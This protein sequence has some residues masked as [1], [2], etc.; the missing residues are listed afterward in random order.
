MAVIQIG[1][2]RVIIRSIGGKIKMILEYHIVFIIITIILL[3]YIIKLLFLD[4]PETK[5]QIT[6]A[7][8][9]SALN[10]LTCQLV[11]LGFFG[12]SII[13]YESTGEIALNLV[14]DEYPLFAYFFLL[15]F[16]NIVFIYV[17]AMKWMNR[18][19]EINAE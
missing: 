18:V 19:W 11:Y 12:I 13:G 6:A 15:Y 9:L 8:I 14:P 10:M 5:E 1:I 17:C 3:L 16:V 2:E 7:S 4:K